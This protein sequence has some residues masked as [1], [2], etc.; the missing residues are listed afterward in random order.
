MA[1]LRYN[2][3]GQNIWPELPILRERILV[4][5]SEQMITGGLREAYRG[6]KFR[7]TYGRGNLSEAQRAVWINNHPAASSFTLI[8]E[9]NVSYTVVLESLSEELERTTPDVPGAASP[10]GP[11]YYRVDVTVREV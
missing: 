9:F 5:R 8:D 3:N 1:T 4:K 6:L 2:V 7:W 11:A 10:T